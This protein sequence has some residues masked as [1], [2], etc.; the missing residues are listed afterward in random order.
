MSAKDPNLF[1]AY[2]FEHGCGRPYQRDDHWLGFF[3]A[4]AERITTDLQPASV[5]DVG[6]AMGFLVEKLRERGIESYGIDISE[7]AIGKVHPDFRSYCHLGSITDPLPGK[8][9]LISCIEVLEHL[10]PADADDAVKNLCE[11]SSRTL[12]SSTPFDYKE[13]T[14]FNVQQPDYWAE[15][16][17]CHGF[18][19]DVDFDAGFVTPWAMLFSSSAVTREHLVRNYERKLWQLT[20][21]ISK[22]QKSPLASRKEL[23]AVEDLKDD[24][25]T[26]I[27]DLEALI[28]ELN[29]ELSDFETLKEEKYRLSVALNKALSEKKV[30]QSE[31]EDLQE[32]HTE[33][34]EKQPENVNQEALLKQVIIDRQSLE[35]KLTEVE[36]HIGWRVLTRFQRFRIRVIPPGTSREML[37]T[38]S[39]KFLHA[40]LSLGISGAIRKTLAKLRGKSIGQTPS[41][42][43][44]AWMEAFELSEQEMRNQR[45][46]VKDFHYRPLISIITPVYNPPSEILDAAINSVL[47]QSYDHWELCIADGSSENSSIQELLSSYSRIDERIKVRFLAANEGIS[48][49]S[50]QALSIAQ[51]EFVA[52][53]DHDDTLAPNTLFEVVKYLNEDPNLDLLYFDEDKLSA[54]GQIRKNPWFKPQWSPELLLSANYLMHSVV[55]RQLVED[56][57]GFDTTMDGAQDWDL[58]LRCA[59]KSQRIRHI[60][61]VLYH[62]REVEGSAASELMAKP[63]VF[64]NQLRCVQGH[65]ERQELE[66]PKTFFD[67]PGFLRVSWPTSGSLVSIIIPSRDN[68]GIL[69]K[70]IGS[71]KSLTTYPNYE[72]LIIDNESQDEE[73][74]AYYTSLQGDSSVRILDFQGEFN[75][76][77]ANNFGASHAKGELLLFLNNDIEIIEADWLEELTRWVENPEIGVVGA[78]LL[79]TNNLIQHAGVIIGMEGHASHVFMG[80]MEKQTGPFGSVDWYRDYVAVTGACLMLR[81]DLFF[82]VGGF[83]EDYLLVFSDVELCLRIWNLGYRNLYNPFVRLRHYE[84]QSRGKLIPA[85]DIQLGY[86]HLRDLVRDGDPYYNPNLSYGVHT[87]SIVKADEISRIERLEQIVAVHLENR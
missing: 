83:D 51:G 22:V 84:G 31:V 23:P 71:I 44:Q 70:C 86:E 49:N 72:I 41:E 18:I 5:L 55:R 75:F 9:D 64:E 28:D 15:L 54:D 7:Y 68:V 6:C 10:D 80:S 67:S 17:A 26:R 47:E 25:E 65:L 4:I 1:D 85:E 36:A 3:D 40:W 45:D 24:L 74:H 57:G 33:L 12:F 63:W 66:N 78:K 39:I 69:Q 82:D 2:Y 19:R 35:G 21:E 58:F 76:S 34:V 38:N 43:Y 48:G 42:D 62:W 60:P 32:R 59:E 53:L 56:V 14:H 46:V 13:S 50:N 79:Y 16:F 61:K 30:F 20:Q 52:L 73:T 81:R 8:Y 11:H 37:W 77:A 29:E 27:I 87:P